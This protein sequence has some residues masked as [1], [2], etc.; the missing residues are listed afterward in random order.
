MEQH[1]QMVTAFP[2]KHQ[3]DCDAKV[4]V[5]A[6]TL[7]RHAWLCSSGLTKETHTRIEDLPFDGVGLFNAKTDEAMDNLQKARNM[8]KRMGFAAPPQQQRY[9]RWNPSPSANFSRY[10]PQRPP[11]QQGH[12]GYQTGSLFHR[13]KPGFS[14]TNLTPLR[15]GAFDFL[16]ASPVTIGIDHHLTLAIDLHTDY[17]H[18]PFGN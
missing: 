5:G 13:P 7:R 2:L 10:Q 15:S 11:Y 1:S 14:A 18:P 12:T 9:R 3:A 8:A 16:S 6:V 17:L 4:M